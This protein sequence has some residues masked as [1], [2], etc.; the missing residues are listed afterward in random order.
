M[1]PE[2]C[3]FL[4]PTLLLFIKC[5]DNISDHAFLISHTSPE[6][7]EKQRKIFVR[8]NYFGESFVKFFRERETCFFMKTLFRCLLTKNLSE[9]IF[10]R[11]LMIYYSRPVGPIDV[12]IVASKNNPLIGVVSGTRASRAV[13]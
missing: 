8:E 4:K 9:Q 6:T 11:L 12:D 10:N 3:F 5:A 7:R 2:F 1:N 13:N